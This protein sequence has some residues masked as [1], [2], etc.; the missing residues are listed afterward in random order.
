MHDCTEDVLAGKYEHMQD[1]QDEVQE[2]VDQ[3]D[4]EYPEYPESNVTIDSKALNQRPELKAVISKVLDPTG[5]LVTDEAILEM[6]NTFPDV[7]EEFNKLFY[8]IQECEAHEGD[9][10]YYPSIIHINDADEILKIEKIGGFRETNDEVA[11]KYAHLSKESIGI[12]YGN[13]RVRRVVSKM[14]SSSITNEL[15]ASM[16]K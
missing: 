8:R 3:H 11:H 12:I 16:L 14:P 2:N 4:S 9:I 6:I 1:T 13:P 7:R 15:V 5:S 10:T